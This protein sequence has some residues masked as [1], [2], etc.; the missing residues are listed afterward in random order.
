M[1][2]ALQIESRIEERTPA[3]PPAEV[4]SETRR[5]WLERFCSELR[6][7]TPAERLRAY[8][9]TFGRRERTIWAARYPEEVPLVG[10]EFEWIALNLE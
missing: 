9:Y 3:P 7:M 8:R 2:Q 5:D 6:R 10:G 1:T 4:V